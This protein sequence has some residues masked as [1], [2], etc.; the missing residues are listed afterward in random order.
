M[1]QLTLENN[2]EESP[3]RTSRRKDKVRF[4]EFMSSK[5][6]KSINTEMMIVINT[7]LFLSE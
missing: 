5:V 3:G 2:M 4:V 7:S 1:K 6:I